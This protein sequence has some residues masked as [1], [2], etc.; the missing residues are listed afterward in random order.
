MAD[1]EPEVP[2]THVL[3]I[4]SH[5]T[6]GY[7]G[8]TMAT[9]CMQA[10]GCEVSAIHTVNYS[11]HVAYKQFK[12][13]K[14]TPEEVA[15]LWAGLRNA[16]LDNF[17][18]LL[19]GYCPS[20][21][22]VEQVGLIARELKSRSYAK[23]GSFF[24]V[25]DPVMGDNGRMYV[26]EETV[27]AYKS[28]LKDADLILPNQFEAE[29]LSDVKIRD[30]ASMKQAITRLHQTYGV[31]HVLI[32]SIRLPATAANTPTQAEVDLA[33]TAK[34]S[35]IGSTATSDMK[36]RLFRITVPAL[37]V[38]FSGTGDMFASLMVARLRQAAQD[39]HL[40]DKPSWRSPDEVSAPDVPLARA[41]EKVLASMHA[42]LK[43]TA[44]HY[45]AAAKKWTEEGQGER[46]SG[47]GDE[48]SE[49]KDTQRH[50]ALTRAAEVRVVRNMKALVSP[51]NLGSFKAQAVDAETHG[52]ADGDI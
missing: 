47:K 17:D 3:A 23:P 18:M 42:A 44:E 48:A 28:L 26:A 34:L 46:K 12:G 43:D 24:W 1:A 31:P 4:A 21:A 41:A 15:D 9:F 6:S 37:A 8:N 45:E 50:L 20:A 25:L 5:V 13:R 10:L 29:L 40:L 22:L 33:T 16:R 19:S 2:E 27:P 7:V 35:I 52:D 36:P 14:T 51:P 49:E 30:L 39:A 38:F 11:N 32:T